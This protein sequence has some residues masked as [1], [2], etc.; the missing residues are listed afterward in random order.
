MEDLTEQIENKRKENDLLY[1]AIQDKNLVVLN[2]KQTI[3]SN[4]SIQ[5]RVDFKEALAKATTKSHLKADESERKLESERKDV[6][7]LICSRKS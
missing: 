5:Q 4:S 1:S 7:E 2:E 3:S 6:T